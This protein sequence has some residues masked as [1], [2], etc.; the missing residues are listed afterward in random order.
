V[1]L[2]DT[3]PWVEGG[4]SDTA[5]AI[6]LG[7]PTREHRRVFD[8]V[9]RSLDLAI[10]LCRPGAVGRK[11]DASVRESLAGFGDSVYKHHTGHGLG[12][13]WNETPQI[14][15]GSQDVI[16][17]GMVIAVEPAIYVPGWGGI[18]LEHVFLVGDRG[19]ELLSR[20][21]HQL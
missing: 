2:T 15:P 21:Q 3:S 7:T 10:T 20:F 12:A 6:V 11:I 13:S 1:V 16:E 17:E 14:I 4:W 5:N 19:N 8:A 9:R 18:R